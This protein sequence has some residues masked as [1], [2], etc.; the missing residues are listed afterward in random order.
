MGLTNKDLENIIKYEDNIL[1][2][3]ESGKENLKFNVYLSEK[4]KDKIKFDNFFLES[5]IEKVHNKNIK[6]LTILDK[7]Y[8]NKLRHIQD[9]PVIL[10]YKGVY[11]D[12]ELAGIVGSRKCTNYGIWACDR[13]TKDL[14][15]LDLGTVSGLALGIDTVAHKST[16]VNGGYTVGVLGNGL[17]KIYPKR[18]KELYNIMEDKHCIISEFTLGTD[19]VAYNFPRRN[20]IIAG[21]S[22]FMIVVEAEEKSG[23]LITAHRSLDQG[24]DVFAIP[25]NINSVFSKGTNKLI[26]DGAIPLLGINDI[27]DYYPELSI[28]NR[29]LNLFEYTTDEL[30]IINVLKDGPRSSEEISYMLNMD[31]SNLNILITE[32]ELKGHIKEISKNIFVQC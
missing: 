32:M 13:F 9:P 24:K 17:D 4:A 3:W 22:K 29:Q 16:I 23:S 26:Q 6:T 14:V 19:P 21:L 10:Y 27:I 5:I 8:P 31:I 11:R 30:L 1:E 2:F 18:N 15:A 20:R 28:E 7:E 25:G 12:V